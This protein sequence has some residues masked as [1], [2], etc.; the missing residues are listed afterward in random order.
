VREGAKARGERGSWRW[1]KESEAGRRRRPGGG[2]G[3]GERKWMRGLG[4]C[5]TAGG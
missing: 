3:G 2:G 4:G 1:G 5:V